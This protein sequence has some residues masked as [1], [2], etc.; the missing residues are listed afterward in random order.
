MAE[1]SDIKLIIALADPTARDVEDLL[2]EHE[3]RMLEACPAHSIHALPSAQLLQP[4]V[5]FWT[6][7]AGNVLAGCGALLAL[8]N[9]HAEIKSMVTAAA[10]R[11]R[12][13]AS[14]ILTVVLTAARESDCTRISLETGRAPYFAPARQLYQ[15]FGFAE[16]GPFGD[17]V[18]DPASLF[19]TRALSP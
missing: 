16:C 2:R 10:L 15:R 8:G 6:A 17:Y 13:V 11:Q 14:A 4:D 12:G 7:R 3:Q 5:R 9:G 19:M 18:D 1:H